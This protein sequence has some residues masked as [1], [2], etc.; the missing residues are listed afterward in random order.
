MA[1]VSDGHHKNIESQNIFVFH[2]PPNKLSRRSQAVT[3][4]TRH[5]GGLQRA[6]EQNG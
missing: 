4:I 2:E 3:A 1:A 5:A 6:G